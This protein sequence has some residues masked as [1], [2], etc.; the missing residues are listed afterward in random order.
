MNNSTNFFDGAYEGIEIKFSFIISYLLG[1]LGSFGL[2]LVIWFER[3]GQ[4]GHFRTLVNQLVS[5]ELDQVKFLLNN[6]CLL[7]RP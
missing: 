4:A 5:F 2:V 1:L 7:T 6:F 3:S